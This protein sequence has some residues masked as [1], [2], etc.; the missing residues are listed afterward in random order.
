MR[1]RPASS[2][3]PSVARGR[4]LLG[5]LRPAYPLKGWLARLFVDLLILNAGYLASFLFRLLASAWRR[6]PAGIDAVVELFLRAG[7]TGAALLSVCGAAL[8][9]ASGLYARSSLVG[10]AC[11]LWP[12]L[13]AAL[14]VLPAYLLV[15]IWF[16]PPSGPAR[17]GGPHGWISLAL[18]WG[19]AGALLWLVR[20]GRSLFG[21]SFLI[22]PRPQATGMAR[23]LQDLAIPD[24]DTD[25]LERARTAPLAAPWPWFGDRMIRAAAD[26]LASGRVNRWTGEE[27]LRFEEEF[28]AFCGVE[29]AIALANGTLALELAL[30][31]LG[32]GPGDEVIVPCRTFI[33]SASCA[34]VRGATPVVVDVDRKSQTLTAETIRP[35]LTEKTKAVICVHLN[36]WPCEMDPILALA[37]ERGLF[38][39]EDCAQAHGARYKGRPVGG[40]G[41]AGAFSFCQD[42][43]MTT[44]GDGGMVVTGDTAL[45]R[46]MWAY[47]DH[48]K[49]YDAVFG[50]QHPPGFRWL[51]KS[52]GTNWRMTEMQA[53]IG[54][55]Q[56]RCLPEWVRIRRSHARMLNDGLGDLVALRL[57]PPPEE[58]DHAYYKYYLFVRPEMLREGWNRDRII[59]ELNARGLPCMQG[60]CGR[61]QDEGAFS[62][63]GRAV[64]SFAGARE[65]METGILFFVHPTLKTEDIRFA[66]AQIRS[67]VSQAQRIPDASPAG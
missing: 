60:I 52:F 56:L 26:V 9:V 8:L 47:K 63:T 54:R 10:R 24:G 17:S 3:T 5:A 14:A 59:A 45:W 20:A 1:G 67:V 30:H 29:H 27:N 32:V 35:A 38:V 19:L 23:H 11:R 13:R 53:A 61:I 64:G 41:H 18:G 22:L 62:Q 43:I 65:L 51:H 34:A 12:S 4:G 15:G 66:V 55:E 48:G 37:R 46:R 36:G 7:W 21:R 39:I 58:I 50:Q 40:M 42:K 6:D 57:T 33:A 2:E 49:D 31:G 25:C 16:L 44:G 28:A